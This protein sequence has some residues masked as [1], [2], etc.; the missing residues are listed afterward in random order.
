MHNISSISFIAALLFTLALPDSFAGEVELFIPAEQAEEYF[1]NEEAIQRQEYQKRF[2]EFKQN[3]QLPPVHENIVVATDVE[4][5]EDGAVTASDTE[6]FATAESFDT[7][8]L[9]EN[10][11]EAAQPLIAEKS[12]TTGIRIHENSLE[13]TNFIVH[14]NSVEHKYTDQILAAKTPDPDR[15]W[16]SASSQATLLFS[17]SAK[18]RDKATRELINNGNWLKVAE[19]LL[20]SPDDISRINGI[21]LLK[22]AADS[23]KYRNI[24]LEEKITKLSPLV[25]PALKDN[26]TKVR[27]LAALILNK[28]TGTDFNYNF[29]SSP[30]SQQEV[31]TA[32]SNYI[33]T[34][35]G[36]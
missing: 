24:P 25:L 23:P 2:A 16:L 30:E 26:N 14:E 18:D 1:Q 28:L 27:F 6:E 9:H 15:V 32:W 10:I 12:N 3:T 5:E 21:N 20:D 36:L 33:Q 31:I 19:K 7:T 35:Y 34:T 8:T 29:N 13:F 22:T 11:P 17:Q 4:K